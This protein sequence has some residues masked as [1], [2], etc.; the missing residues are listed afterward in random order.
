MDAGKDRGDQL[1]KDGSAGARDNVPQTLGFK[2]RR[3]VLA[4]TRYFTQIA[5]KGTI[6]TRQLGSLSL[7]YRNPGLTPSELKFML[8]LDAAQLT[9]IIRQLENRSLIRREKS[10]VDHRSY[11]L[12]TTDEGADEY[13]RMQK[14]IREAEDGYFGTVLDADE[15]QVLIGML[16]RLLVSSKE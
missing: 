4:Y 16:D 12:Y 2:L 6:P 10:P 8:M 1:R 9:A 13:R 3:V 7:I 11:Q 15:K 14:I 5:P